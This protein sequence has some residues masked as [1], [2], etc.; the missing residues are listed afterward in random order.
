MMGHLFGRWCCCPRVWLDESC[1]CV[2]TVCACNS[3]FMCAYVHLCAAVY[4]VNGLHSKY[5][6]RVVQKES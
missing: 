3:G 5:E 1:I 4:W 6:C 2:M